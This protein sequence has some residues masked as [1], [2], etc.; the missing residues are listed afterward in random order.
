[1]DL[2]WFEAAAEAAAAARPQDSAGSA[3]RPTAR[4]VGLWPAPGAISMA[5][6]AAQAAWVA[7]M[8]QLEHSGLAAGPGSAKTDRVALAEGRRTVTFE[9]EPMLRLRCPPAKRRRRKVAA[10]FCVAWCSLAPW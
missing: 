9:C 8:F 5:R 3:R 4:I 10:A 1:M 6:S 7:L 2:T